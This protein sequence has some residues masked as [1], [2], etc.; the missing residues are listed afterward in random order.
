MKLISKRIWISALALL[1][2]YIFIMVICL[3]KTDYEAIMT[4][5]ISNVE[6]LIE[7]ESDYKE[8]GSFNSVY[9]LTYEHTSILQNWILGNSTK[10]DTQD[11]SY[12]NHLS[13]KESSSMGTISHDSSVMYSL[14][15]AYNEASYD[16]E[17]IFLD[18]ELSGV[19]IYYRSKNSNLRVNDFIVKVN[20]YDVRQNAL[21]FKE[22]FN[23][24][25]IG[26]IFTVIRDDEEIEIP[27]EWDPANENWFSIYA[28][29][30]INYENSYPK[31]NV[32]ASTS[33]GPSAG[34]LQTLSIF[35]RLQERDYTSGLKICGTG[36]MDTQGNV[37]A[38]G[39]IK[40]KV[41]TASNNNVD[42]FFCP[43][44]NEEEGVLAYNSLSKKK[45]EKMDFVV[46]ETFSDVT[47]YLRG[48]YEKLN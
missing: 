27:Y 16:D 45:R 5:G 10:N 35:N 6:N 22:A 11:N 26:D 41:I 44:A 9:V 48:L 46:V 2:P 34:L 4:G 3:Y 39:G 17:N 40:Q 25:Q 7:I 24:K 18:Y 38:I 14:I 15:L 1:I 43:K 12:S 23:N 13:S 20:D 29:Y 19:K 32:N 37:G 33:K 42:V 8:E 36:T 30:D 47:S 21:E 31:I 28:Y